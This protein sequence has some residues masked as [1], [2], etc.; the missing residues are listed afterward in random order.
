MLLRLP[1]QIISKHAVIRN[2]MVNYIKAERQIL[3][4][5]TDDAGIVKLYYT[6][7][8]DSKWWA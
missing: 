4:Q 7:Q 1:P 2:K 5:L 3:D 8:D 6:F